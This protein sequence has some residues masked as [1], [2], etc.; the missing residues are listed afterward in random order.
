M[1]RLATI[2]VAKPSASLQCGSIQ[3]IS[4]YIDRTV[5]GAPLHDGQPSCIDQFGHRDGGARLF[6]EKVKLRGTFS[7]IVGQLYLEGLVDRPHFSDPVI[8][9]PCVRLES[10]ILST[11]FV[12]KCSSQTLPQPIR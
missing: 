1:L 6:R 12:Q 2:I 5:E 10:T 7:Q 11:S 8:K 9:D 4:I 3:D